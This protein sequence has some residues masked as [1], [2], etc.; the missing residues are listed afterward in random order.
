LDIT[1]KEVRD[2]LAKEKKDIQQKHRTEHRAGRHVLFPRAIIRITEPEIIS[3]P[4]SS[5]PGNSAAPRKLLNG[6]PEKT[7]AEKAELLEQLKAEAAKARDQQAKS[8]S[9]QPVNLDGHKFTCPI[10]AC[11]KLFTFDGLNIHLSH[12][13]GMDYPDLKL[14]RARIITWLLQILQAK[15]QNMP[16]LVAAKSVAKTP[17]QAKAKAVVKPAA[18]PK[19]KPKSRIIR[20]KPA[21]HKQKRTAKGKK[22]AKGRGKPIKMPRLDES[23]SEE[24]D[25]DSET[26]P[27]EDSEEERE[28]LE[29]LVKNRGRKRN[30]TSPK[31]LAEWY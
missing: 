26:T 2:Y 27:D 17:V 7:A 20:T 28:Y 3:T 18:P 29:W 14:M 11:N 19:L 31:P 9:K 22:S 5:K 30:S 13:L 25:T 12:C 16:A 24:E 1:W 23:E 15:Q 21:A 10:C 4:P 8:G 6:K